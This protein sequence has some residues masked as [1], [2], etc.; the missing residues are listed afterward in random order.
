MV[1]PGMGLFLTWAPHSRP[2][3]DYNGVVPGILGPARAAN[4]KEM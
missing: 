3:F 2:F 1:P 4:H